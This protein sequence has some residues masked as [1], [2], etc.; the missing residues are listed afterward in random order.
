MGIGYSLGNLGLV[1]LHQGDHA[2]AQQAFEE[3]RTIFQAQGNTRHEAFAL[4]N[5]GMVVSHQGHHAL[6][7]SRF[8]ASLRIKEQIGDKWGSAS[9]LVY[10]AGVTRAQGELETT[11]E[12]LRRSLVL[13]QELADWGGLAETLDG[14][15]GYAAA[16][17]R[18]DE[19]ARFLGAAEALRAA[20]HVVLHTADRIAR[21]G[22]AA[23]A[24]AQLGDEPFAK[25]WEY[26]RLLTGDEAVALALA[27]VA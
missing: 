16:R 24:R 5:L 10:L 26:G 12:L 6:A 2:A 23:D 15:A 18:P 9:S 17:R 19:A 20:R 7:R 11:R 1:Y 8:E 4:H 13:R 27:L 21:D 3:S 22:N 25:A 14:I